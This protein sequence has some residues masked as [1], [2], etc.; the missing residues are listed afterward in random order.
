MQPINYEIDGAQGTRAVSESDLQKVRDLTAASA[1][2]F[3]CLKEL[4]AWASKTKT[5]AIFKR[6]HIQSKAYSESIEE[7]LSV[8]N[9][10]LA[11]SFHALETYKEGYIISPVTQIKMMKDANEMFK[12]S[13][14]VKTAFRDLRKELLSIKRDNGDA[15]YS[16]LHVCDKKLDALDLTAQALQR[17]VDVV[18]N[19]VDW[20]DSILVIEE[21]A[22]HWK[23][24]LAEEGCRSIWLRLESEFKAYRSEIMKQQDY[25]EPLMVVRHKSWLMRKAEAVGRALKPSK[26]S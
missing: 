10:G 25:Y 26:S 2:T 11:I 1:E 13:S 23:M 3:E 5:S 21:Q 4:Q 8:A 15:T 22:L 9:Y 12:K 20:W 16:S 19:F 7:S 17:L 6:V 14:E 24:R 18:G